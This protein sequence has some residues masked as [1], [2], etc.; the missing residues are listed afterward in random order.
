MAKLF[1]QSPLN[2]VWE[3]SGN[4]MALDILR[5]YK[6]LPAL[7]A[8]INSSRGADSSLDQYVASLE[9]SIAAFAKDPSSAHSQRSARNLVDRLA[10]ALQGSVMVRY[11]D[12]KVSTVCSQNVYNLLSM[13]CRPPRRLLLRGSS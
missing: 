8:D 11:G 13:C 3:G 5:G 7:F 6:A 12:A 2:S 4:V 10:T 1:R 9:K